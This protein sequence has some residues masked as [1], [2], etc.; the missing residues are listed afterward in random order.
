MIPPWLV[1]EGRRTVEEEGKRCHRQD[2]DS[3][4]KYQGYGEV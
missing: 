4:E 2:L 1:R 3:Q